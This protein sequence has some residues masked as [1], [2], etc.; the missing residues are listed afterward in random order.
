MA[1]RP[2]AAVVGN[3]AMF[4]Q[5]LGR[6]NEAIAATLYQLEQDPANPRV[7]YNLTSTYYYAG[8]WDDAIAMGNTTL[9]MSPARTGVRSTI[10]QALLHKGNARAA[11]DQAKAEPSEESRLLALAMVHH[12]LGQKD[13]S[14]SALAAM[15]D[16]FGNDEPFAVAS[17]Y[18]YRGEASDAFKWLERAAV[19]G[20]VANITIDPAFRPIHRDPRWMPFLRTIGKAPEQLAAIP[21]TLTTPK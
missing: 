12:A 2:N 13:Q 14:D 19:Q 20:G 9:A 3:A 21:F 11:L 10:A 7:P 15:I 5:N 6:S 4:L 16:R 1:N 18:A 17:V 8:R